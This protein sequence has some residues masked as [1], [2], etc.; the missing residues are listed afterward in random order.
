MKTYI[1]PAVTILCNNAWAMDNRTK[2]QSNSIPK[3]ISNNHISEDCVN[4]ICQASG[5]REKNVQNLDN[6][7]KNIIDVHEKTLCIR[8]K[9]LTPTTFLRHSLEWTYSSKH[10][11]LQ[12]KL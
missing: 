8:N 7:G 12:A 5:Y 1:I 10:T 2:N 6:L 3:K 11:K 9:K 4:L